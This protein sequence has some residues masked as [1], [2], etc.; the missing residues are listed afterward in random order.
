MAAEPDPDRALADLRALRELTE[1]ER[2]A[3]RV[4]WTDTWAR[5]ARGSRAPRRAAGERRHATRP[6]TSGRSSPGRAPDT[7]VLGSHID[8][9]P[10]GGWLDGALGVLGGLEVLRT[11]AASGSRP[12]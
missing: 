2:G 4:A 12:P 7:V 11:L 8:S 6:A 9:V 10:D 3:Q 5:R 1:D